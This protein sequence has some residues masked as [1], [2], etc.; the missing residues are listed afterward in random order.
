MT[1]LATIT[2]KRQLTIP[3][4]IFTK[5]GLRRQQKVFIEEDGGIIFLTPMENLVQR[6]ASSLP[7]PKQW[8]NKN[9]EEIIATAK[10]EHFL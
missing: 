8:Q 7:V 1:Q 9:I 4:A 5:A 2:S 6:L 10:Q 3:V